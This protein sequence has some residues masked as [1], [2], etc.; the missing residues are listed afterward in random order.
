MFLV[1][2]TDARCMI[3]YWRD[4]IVCLSVR[5]SVTKYIEAIRVGVWVEIYYDSNMYYVPVLIMKAIATLHYFKICIIL[6]TTLLM[7]TPIYS[8]G[9]K[10]R[11]TFIFTITLANVDRFQ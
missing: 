6:I 8:V 7:F 3:G 5:R 2:R 4:T 10:K 11:A 9:H 1:D